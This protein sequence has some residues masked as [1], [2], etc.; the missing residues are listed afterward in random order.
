MTAAAVPTTA[1]GLFG[2]GPDRPVAPDPVAPLIT[3]ALDLAGRYE[4]AIVAF[5]ELA[6]RLTP[7]AAAHRAHAAALAGISGVALPSTSPE[8]SATAA[9]ALPGAAKELLAVLRTAEQEA[10]RAAAAVCALAPAERAGL[11]G[12]IAAAR[13]THV[14]ALR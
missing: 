4:A 9:P 2:A 1:C 3:A 8:P 14:E 10:H 6:E 13:A 11:L 5:P 12:A 7:L